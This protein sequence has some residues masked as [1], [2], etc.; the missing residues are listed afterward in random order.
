MA[1]VSVIPGVG[2]AHGAKSR[3][4]SPF[5]LVAAAGAAVIRWLERSQQRRALQRLDDRMLRDIGLSRADVAG[6]SAKPFW[7][8]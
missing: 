6:E 5:R 2:P 3:R 8:A 4:R 1:Q 7:R